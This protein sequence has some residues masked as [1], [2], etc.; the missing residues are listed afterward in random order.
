M[1]SSLW[2][3]KLDRRNYASWS[4]KMQQYLLRH[5]YWSYGEGAIDAAS[6]VTHKDFP[7]W[8]QAASTVMYCFTS[9]VALFIGRMNPIF[10]SL[11]I[12]HALSKAMPSLLTSSTPKLVYD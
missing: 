3:E 1:G 7:A 2:T 9:S 8:E 11:S 4:H 6:D 10:K 5:G 12:S